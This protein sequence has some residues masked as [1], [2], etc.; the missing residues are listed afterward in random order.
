MILLFYDE[1]VGWMDYWFFHP[2]NKL[3]QGKYENMALCAFAWLFLAPDVGAASIIQDINNGDAICLACKTPTNHTAENS[4]IAFVS[5]GCL[6]HNVCCLSIRQPDK[7]PPF[8]T[9]S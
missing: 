3:T 2:S 5:I 6:S 8:R 9:P 1:L 7:A 4:K